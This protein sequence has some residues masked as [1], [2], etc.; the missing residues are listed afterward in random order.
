MK[1]NEI[2]FVFLSKLLDGQVYDRSRHSHS[3]LDHGH[4]IKQNLMIANHRPGFMILL[5]Y[6]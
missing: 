5:L 3:I 4:I 1:C 6:Y 2:G